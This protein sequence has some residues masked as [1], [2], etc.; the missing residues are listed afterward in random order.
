MLFFANLL[1]VV[2]AS[3]LS[4]HSLPTEST[5]IN[6]WS[7]CQDRQGNM[8]FGGTDGVTRYDGSRYTDFRYNVG[9]AGNRGEDHVYQLFCDED[10]TLWAGHLTGLSSFDYDSGVF[11][12]HPSPDGSVRDVLQIDDSHFLVVAAHRLWSFDKDRG[13][14]DR[15]ALPSAVRDLP[16]NMLYCEGNMIYIGTRDGR[17]IALNRELQILQEIATGFEGTQVNCLLQDGP[18]RLWAGTEGKGLWEISLSGEV[19]PK[20]CGLDYVRALCTDEDG[21]LWIGTKNGLHILRDGQ[22]EVYH[23]DYYDSGSITH[24]SI[25]SIVRDAQGTMWL[26]TY[27]GGVCYCTSHPSLFTCYVSRPGEQFLNGQIVSDIVEDRDGSLWIGTNSGGLNHLLSD[28]R[29]EHIEGF[30]EGYSDQP[31]IKSIYI[32]PVSGRIFVGA[33]KGELSVVQPRTKRL[34]SLDAGI[35]NGSYAMAPSPDGAIYVGTQDGLYRYDELSGSLTVIP[36]PGPASNI[37]ALELDGD[38]TLWIGRKF[39]VVAM[40]TDSGEEIPLPER[41]AG[42]RYV[43]DFLEDCAG[44]I[45]I[46][47]SDGL[48]RYDKTDGSVRDYTLEDGLPDN[49]IH[50]VEEDSRGN[51]WIST[52]RGLCRLN[53]DTGEK[54]IFTVADGLPGDRFT[55]YAH[56]RTRSGEMYFGGLSWLVRFHPD[57]I[58][59]SYKT[60]AP[61]LTGIEVNGVRRPLGGTSLSLRPDDRDVSF[62]FT[63]PDYVSG[64]NGHF[65][66]KIEGLGLYDNWH[67]AGLDRM[68]SYH[69]L[70][71]GDYTF[72]LQYRNSAGVTSPEQLCFSFTIPPHWWET[73]TFR[74]LL[75]FFLSLLFVIFVRWLLERK[76]AE[77]QTE[78]EKVRNELLSEFSLEFVRI[79]ADKS[80]P[81]ESSV[82]RVFYKGDE[83]F[84]RKAMQVVKKNLDNPDFTVEALASEMNMS[85]SNLHIRAKALFGVSSH[86]FI[87]TVRFNEACRLL[88][89]KKHSVAEIGYMVGFTTPS[90]FASAFHRFMGCTPTEYVRQNTPEE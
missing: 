58:D 35:R 63:A 22:L 47:S 42:I 40:S 73:L 81:N 8:W 51:L 24:D 70:S 48:L 28:G 55:A 37:K 31:D 80:A 4:F 49:V 25:L 69:G 67:E 53:P 62:L 6:V 78:M 61:V 82:A 7:V 56:C 13:S 2:V 1:P 77:Y 45:W 43:E 50:G 17:I 9:G 72:H 88:L 52:N 23:H 32:S 20:G 46:S 26:G 89:E 3:A 57:A 74:A 66:Y 29:F 71:Y 65:F 27:Y 36:V 79:G 21:I 12:N 87:K 33:D 75:I 15:E 59:P 68:A 11:R 18:D 64:Q 85:R 16:V 90:Y 38:G 86:E 76:K 5:G 60:V 19:P 10:G 84:M 34:Q 14:Y 54:R 30:G 39:G 41:L 83:E 44:R